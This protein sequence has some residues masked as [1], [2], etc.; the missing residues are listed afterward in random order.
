MSAPRL[1]VVLLLAALVA[2]SCGGPAP[3]T[4]TSEGTG[5][6]PAAAFELTILPWDRCRELDAAS[7]DPAEAERI[8]AVMDTRGQL[9]VLTLDDVEAYDPV[10]LV[11]VVKA[12]AIERVASQTG[13]PTEMADLGLGFGCFVLAIGGQR[14][15]GG[16]TKDIGS[17]TAPNIPVL[18]P[19]STGGGL[20][21]WIRPIGGLLSN[22]I[23]PTLWSRI[24]PEELRSYFGG[25]GKLVSP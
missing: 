23:D 25:A 7:D 14:L 5:V 11:I 16:L 2:S 24:H 17:A 8:V 9:A 12:S 3:T 19:D 21:L 20:R 13:S 15:F 22:H 1:G 10:D 6:G 4:Q 18:F